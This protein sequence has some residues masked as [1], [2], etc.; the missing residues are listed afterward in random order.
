MIPVGVF[1][2]F[3]EMIDALAATWRVVKI[4]LIAAA[5]L[6]A[7]AIVSLAIVAMIR[8]AGD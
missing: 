2:P 6:G 1:K 4:I 5:Y 3:G 7:F 8:F